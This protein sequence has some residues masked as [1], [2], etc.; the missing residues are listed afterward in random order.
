MSD[1]KR[2]EPEK[3]KAPWFKVLG[4]SPMIEAVLFDLDDTLLGNNMEQF[5]SQY[6]VML[7]EYAQPYLDRD[8]FLK[9]LL[10]STQAAMANTDTAVSNREVFWAVFQ[11]RTGLDPAELEPF[12]DEFY[13]HQFPRLQTVTEHRPVAADLVRLCFE[14]GAKVVVAT[15]PV[16]PRAAIEERLLWAGVPVTE[17]PYA[18]VTTYENMYATKPHQAYYRQILNTVEVVPEATLMV[19][20]DWKNDVEPTAALSMFNYWVSDKAIPPDETLVTDYGSL[21]NLHALLASGWL[22]QLTAPDGG[23]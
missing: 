4:C 6:F 16:F 19:G 5:I 10:F 9:E 17:F 21:S 7:G 8:T 22:R 11:E 20:D 18:L 15:N 2:G 1:G 23:P 12:F 13:R 3:E 14:Q